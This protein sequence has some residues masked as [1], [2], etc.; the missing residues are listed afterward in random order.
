MVGGDHR[1]GQVG[2]DL[3]VPLELLA[4]QPLPRN[5]GSIVSPARGAASS[6]SISSAAPSSAAYRWVAAPPLPLRR[7]PDA[8]HVLDDEVVSRYVC[9]AS[10]TAHHSHTSL[11]S[12]DTKGTAL[13]H[14]A[15]APQR[16]TPG[17]RG[18]HIGLT[19]RRAPP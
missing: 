15:R 6:P 11:T 4:Q 3:A 9:C 10:S 14:S 13:S 8:V 19:R 17:L 5:I 18:A 1:L 7:P 12:T 16:V 2:A